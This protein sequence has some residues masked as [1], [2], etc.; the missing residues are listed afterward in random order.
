MNSFRN[1]FTSR[2]LFWTGVIFS[3][4]SGVL[5]YYFFSGRDI[6]ILNSFRRMV[7]KYINIFPYT[8]N[9]TNLK[10]FFIRE[11]IW[12]SGLL[13]YGFISVVFYSRQL[14]NVKKNIINY[15]LNSLIVGIIGIITL[16][17][18]NILLAVSIIGFPMAVFLLIG[19]FF[20]GCFG[21]ISISL[22]IGD[23]ISRHK[24]DSRINLLFKVMSG[25]II[26]ETIKVIPYLGLSLYLILISIGLGSVAVTRFGTITF[27]RES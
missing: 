8:L 1:R 14:L 12:S 26:L 13:F 16:I 6:Q 2:W 3:I 22:L 27:Q 17:F 20:A 19:F 15:P 23:F 21:L 9:Q 24:N 4:G 25:L 5:F 18:L 7:I 11:I 10:E